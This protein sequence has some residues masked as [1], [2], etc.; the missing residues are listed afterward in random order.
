MYPTSTTVGPVP[1]R[2]NGSFSH[3]VILSPFS[4]HVLVPD[5][6]ADLI[7][8]FTFDSE[9]VAPLTERKPLRTWPGAGPRHGVF[10]QAPRKG[11]GEKEWFLLFNGELSQRVYTYRVTC[12]GDELAWEKV[13]EVVALGE[14]GEGLEGN[15]APTSGIAVSVSLPFLSLDL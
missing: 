7:R 8:V 15:T 3:H 14:L 9:N 12:I 6:G 2:Q 5:L 10:W 11:S 1:S 4:N 13:S